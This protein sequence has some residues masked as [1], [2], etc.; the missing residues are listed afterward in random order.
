MPLS[1]PSRPVWVEISRRALLHNHAVLHRRAHAIDAELVCVVKANAYGHGAAQCLS[2]LQGA[3]AG[4]FAVT[5]VEEALPLMDSGPERMLVLS[6]LYRGEADTAVE[7]GLTP[8]LSSPEQARW[9]HLA[10]ERRGRDSYSAHLEVDTGMARQGV[11][12]DDAA[13]QDAIAQQF[14]P[15]SLLH[16]E[17]VMTHFASPEDTASP[18]T[19]QQMERFASAVAHIRRSVAALPIVHCGNSTTLFDPE[20]AE[21]LQR[22]AWTHGARLL[23]RPGIALYGYGVHAQREGLEPVLAWKTQVTALR[24]LEA[25]EAVSY[26]ATF[27]AKR[28]TRI[29][30]LPVGYADGYNRL[31]S[32]RGEVLVRGRRVPVAGRVTMDQTMVDVTDVPEAEIGDEVVLLGRQA[33]EAITADDLA[34]LTG[35]IAYEVLCA[36][37][38]RVPRVAVG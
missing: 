25:G 12:W 5:S 13:T 37:G 1:R 8:V 31:L 14:G 30:L 7:H 15:G 10:V 29:A 20:Q 16:L 18:Q 21:P 2:W 17:G 22:I 28:R 33:G 26:N 36:I 32:N 4:W 38:A 27:V 19:G 3:G 35:T 24:T 23:L 34:K 6:G 9:L 11:R